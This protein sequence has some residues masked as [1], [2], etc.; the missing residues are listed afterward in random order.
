M[1]DYRLYYYDGYG[2]LKKHNSRYHKFKSVEE[3]DVYIERIRTI[4][5]HKFTNR[6]DTYTQYVLIDYNGTDSHHSLITKVYN[7]I[8]V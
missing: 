5:K 7:P 3:C 1:N 4:P 6:I 2:T 8:S